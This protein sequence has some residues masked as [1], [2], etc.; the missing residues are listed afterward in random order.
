M[1]FP[2][3]KFLKLQISKITNTAVINNFVYIY[4]HV[5]GLSSR[6]DWQTLDQNV[7]REYAVCHISEG[8]FQL[9]IP[10]TVYDSVCFPHLH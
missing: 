8:L 9:A 5:G 4:F 2:N 6:V 7:F 1:L 3:Y 10:S